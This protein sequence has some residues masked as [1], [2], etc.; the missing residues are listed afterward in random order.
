MLYRLR[1]GLHIEL[2]GREYVIERR[3]PDGQ[4]EIRDVVLN[5]V[6][7]V[8][9]HSLVDSLFGGQLELL[10]DSQRHSLAER[11]AARAWITDLSL[12]EDG[13]REET[14]QRY[15]YVCAVKAQGVTKY[16]AEVLDPIIKRVSLE[17]ADAAPPSAITL[18]RWL[19]RYQ[20]S[21]EDIRALSPAFKRRGNR[22]RRLSG[23][24]PSKSEAVAKIIDD[25]INEKY[26][27]RHRP[28]VESIC[29]TINARITSENRLREPGERLS[30]PHRSSVY[31]I[32]NKLDVY[33][34]V[35]ARYGQRIADNRYKAVKLGP[36][37]TRPLERVE[38]DHTKL[39]ML[40][41]D[42]V[43]RLPVG[44]P[45]M[46][47][48]ID[49]FS[50]MILG[51]YVSFNP[52]GYISV[53][54]CLLHAIRPKTYLKERFPEI[55]NTWDAYG[56]PELIV[57]DN[58]PEFY[59]RHFEDGCLQ[60]GIGVHYAPPK[61][62]QFKG[63]EERWFRTQNQQL[64]HGQPGTTFSNV[65][66]RADY[67][68][69]KNA[70]ISY[71]ALEEMAHTFIVDVYHRRE[72]RGLGDVPARVW[73]HAIAEFPPPLPPKSTELQVLLGC[74]EQRTISAKGVE[75]YSLFYNDERLA[76][77]RC[78][79]KAGDKVTV[80]Y[81]PADLSMIHVADTDKEEYI[82][83]PAV[84]QAYAA[85]LTL[86]QH[87]VIK[88]FARQTIKD[89][90]DTV[91]LCLAKERIQQIVE[92]EWLATKKTTTRQR[93]ARLKNYGQPPQGAGSAPAKSQ[94]NLRLLAGA[95]GRNITLLTPGGAW[96]GVSATGSATDTAQSSADDST[97]V[98]DESV[99]VL[100]SSTT[101]D[102][103]SKKTRPSRKTV[104]KD[105]QAHTHEEAE[106]DMTGWDADFNL[107]K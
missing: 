94:D 44:R 57:V 106:L 30:F 62:G 82:P 101:P 66:D 41:V 36:R 13:V 27:S 76:K 92:R 45:W 18:Y 24:D 73:K 89:E 96:D 19:R 54:G 20:V 104:P 4:L 84:N 1:K 21:G 9:E 78:R 48:A 49:K 46:T 47:T 15:S 60:L 6:T 26:L 51:M 83:V 25:V 74:I 52:P 32:V 58:G 103:A 50:R 90:V 102:R 22:L 40:V 70:V 16:T 75:L 100:P 59:S 56:V 95:K 81:D 87:N 61:M 85:G 29:A 68:P 64:L 53:M 72:H 43:M 107:P 35:K 10:G 34:V 8:A 2:R 80:K 63:T 23:G 5:E 97:G 38:I 86:W 31:D 65:I 7:S 77:L 98:S 42:E 11:R 39:D 17:I 105:N 37:P 67:D 99:G 93:I 91:A 3:L 33:E 55:Q 79:L 69:K 14:K 12:L 88:R 28:T 71:K